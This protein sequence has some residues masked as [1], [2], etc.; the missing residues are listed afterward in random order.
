MARKLDEEQMWVLSDPPTAAA[1]LDTENEAFWRQLA[2]RRD[3]RFNLPEG[4][5]WWG[6]HPP[7]FTNW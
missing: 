7:E 4:D 1:S 2:E 6:K 3:R 5:V